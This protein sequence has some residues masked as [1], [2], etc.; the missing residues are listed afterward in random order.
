MPRRDP[1]DER[2]L[3]ILDEIW[4][5]PIPTGPVTLSED[6]LRVVRYVER[7]PENRSGA[8]KTWVYRSQRQFREYFARARR[9]R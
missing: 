6:Y 7:L 4:K 9:V 2:A 5:A 8:D 3:R 1:G